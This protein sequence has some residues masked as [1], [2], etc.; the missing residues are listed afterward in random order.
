MGYNLYYGADEVQWGAT[1]S[2]VIQ[3]NVRKFSGQRCVTDHANIWF[4]LSYSWL[5][6]DLLDNLPVNC[7]ES[8][9]HF[10]PS[11]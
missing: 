1:A 6:S 2:S 5:V 8:V 3:L 9:T 7:I 10:S 11:L 4:R